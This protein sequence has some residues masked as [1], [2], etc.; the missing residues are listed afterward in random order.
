MKRVSLFMILS[1]SLLSCQNQTQK[2]FNNF[3]AKLTEKGF[4]WQLGE[5][6]FLFSANEEVYY[7]RNTSSTKSV[8]SIGKW[9]F[10]K[11]IGMLQIAWQNQKQIEVEITTIDEGFNKIEFIGKINDVSIERGT[12]TKMKLLDNRFDDFLH[13]VQDIPNNAVKGDYNGDGK[14]EFAWVINA[15]TDGES[16]KDICEC[17][18]TFSNKSIPKF[19]VGKSCVT[20][21]IRNEGDL[22]DNEIDDLSVVTHG[23]NGTWAGV[24]VYTNRNGNWVDLVKPFSYWVGGDVTDFIRKDDTKKGHVII[25]EY[26]DSEIVS[27][28]VVVK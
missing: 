13:G 11:D 9:Y 17:F 20:G 16:C 7:L 24:Y 28:S 22:N 26:V 10:N 25:T 14:T 4:F 8:E 21:R 6:A 12:L 27:R 2:Q 5:E 18:V 3:E 1:I 23:F 15:E 19:K